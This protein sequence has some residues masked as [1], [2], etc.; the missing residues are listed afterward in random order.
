MSKR[1]VSHPRSRYLL[2]RLPLVIY[3]ILFASGLHPGDP[4]VLRLPGKR[5]ALSLL[6]GGRSDG[7]DHGHR[8]RAVGGRG[9]LG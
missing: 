4:R 9:P 7:P 5:Q 8:G 6:G 3:P 2:F 1:F